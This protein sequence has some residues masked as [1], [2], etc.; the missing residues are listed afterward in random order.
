MLSTEVTGVTVSHKNSFLCL[1]YL[2]L[3]YQDLLISPTF[4]L[5][6]QDTKLELQQ[7]FTP[8]RGLS[9]SLTTSAPYSF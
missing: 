9:F 3:L 4:H 1:V 8:H 2:V 6:Q 7:Q 5:Y